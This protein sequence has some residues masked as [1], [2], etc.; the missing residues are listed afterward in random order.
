MAWNDPA[1]EIDTVITNSWTSSNADGVTPIISD[2]V[3]YKIGD[4]RNNDYVFIQLID[5]ATTPCGLGKTLKN[6]ESRIQID[7]IVG[8][9]A[10]ASTIHTHATNVL[11]EAIRCLDNNITGLTNFTY[12]NQKY[13]IR[14]ISDK[15]RGFYRFVIETVLYGKNVT[16]T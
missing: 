12:G 2:I 15:G 1:D 14:D 5:E 11:K 10:T 3:D 16:R 13:T 9:K 6:T 8:R 7:V 4:L